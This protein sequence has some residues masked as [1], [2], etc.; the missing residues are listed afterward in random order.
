VRGL[1]LA[2]PVFL[3]AFGVYVWTAAPSVGPGHDSGELTVA[4]Y[5]LGVAHP[6]GYPLFVRLAHGW[7]Q[8]WGGDYGWRINLFSGFCTALA[9]ALLADLLRRATG[10]RVAALVG[11]LGFA[12][13]GSVWGQAVIAEV[14]G[15]HFAITMGLGWLGW[16]VLE[17][18]GERRWLW[19]FYACLGLG[20]AHHHTFVLALPGLLWMAWPHWRRVLLTPAW[21][22]TLGVAGLFYLDMWWRAQGQPT[23]NW[24]GLHTLDDVLGHFLRR[25]YGTFQL[26]R[27]ADS[28]DRGVVHGAAYLL[29]T[30]ARQ[31]P[32]AWVLLAL[33]GGWTGRSRPLGRLGWGWL[34]AFGPFFALIG[35]QRLDTF[36]LD[37]LER[38]YASSYLGLA[39]LAGLGAAD[40]SRRMGPRRFGV[41][42]VAL[43]GW[44]FWSNLPAC[45]LDQRE[46]VASYARQLLDNCPPG[47][48]LVVT[49][50]LPVGAV[51]YVQQVESYRTEVPVVCNGLFGG[52]WYRR[53]L[54][55]WVQPYL[56]GRPKVADLARGFQQGGL[57]VFMMLS[58]ELPGEARPRRLGWEWQPKD[59]SGRVE[60]ECLRAQIAD[61]EK[62]RPGLGRESRF[63][64]RYLISARISNLRALAAAVYAQD[65]ELA[66]AG[67]DLV[68]ELGDG[69]SLDR[70][71]RGLL[72]QRLGR[73][74]L[75]LEDFE[76]CP[77][78][79]LAQVA[80]VYSQTCL[81]LEDLKI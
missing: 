53:S 15:L 81:A 16:R 52:E 39:L 63:W 30:Y 5:C 27:K 70:L 17:N 75:A 48:M 3:L 21:L 8:L 78:E 35:R 64:P 54:P 11:G 28:L 49:G 58:G 2:L 41:V 57:P 72:R 50:D 66:L 14:F 42:A 69:R 77:D 67:L 38:F 22:A 4:A 73:H 29:F 40:L 18:P 44:Q 71:N 23:L 62:L 24:G 33:W 68:V 13:L 60:R 6:P 47:S 51:A 65:A 10:S 9:A 1:P 25:S 19:G 34:I 43:L 80:L 31:A 37:M 36:H 32:F 79:A 74:R 59:R 76:Q 7:G 56:N 61:A 55:S 20:L 45:R 46:L 12:W 26:T